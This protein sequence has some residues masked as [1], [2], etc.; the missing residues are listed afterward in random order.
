MGECNVLKLLYVDDE[1]ELAD[2]VVRSLRLDRGLDVR[3]LHSGAE[4]IALAAENPWRPDA[5][6]LDVMMPDLNGPDTFTHLRDILGKQV[7]IIF[8]TAQ[9]QRSTVQRLLAHGAAGVLIKPF[10]PLR[11]AQ[12]ARRLIEAWPDRA[13]L[14]QAAGLAHEPMLPMTCAAPVK[15]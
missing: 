9:A 8:F 1:P 6:L 2:V 11:L 10:E 4:A 14:P 7:P 3:A 13:A 15:T 12:D 5:V